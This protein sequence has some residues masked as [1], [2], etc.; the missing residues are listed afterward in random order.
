MYKDCTKYNTIH[1]FLINYGILHIRYLL[2]T[3]PDGENHNDTYELRQF[4]L[5]DFNYNY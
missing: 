3:I 5:Y 4:I 1:F 2:G